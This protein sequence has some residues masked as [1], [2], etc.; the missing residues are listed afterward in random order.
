MSLIPLLDG[1]Y[2]NNR[3]GAVMTGDP[4]RQWQRMAI[5]QRGG[6]SSL[7]LG[8]SGAALAFSTSLLTSEKPEFIGFWSSVAFQVHAVLQLISMGCSVSFNLNRLKDFHVTMKI[9]RDRDELCEDE[10]RG[11][12]ATSRRLGSRTLVLFTWQC[13]SFIASMV[14]FLLFSVIRLSRLLY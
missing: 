3:L 13:W 8:L 1:N 4:F 5:E 14:F 12:R 9:A 11:L 7:M 2:F 10:V 6:A